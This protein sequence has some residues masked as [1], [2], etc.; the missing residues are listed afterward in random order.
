MA[1]CLMAP[2]KRL[3]NL[4]THS[5]T[6]WWHQAI[7]WTIVDLISEVHCHSIH[8]RVIFTQILK[9][10]IPKLC[11]KFTHL[12]ALPYLP[13][14][15]KLI[16]YYNNCLISAMR[17]LMLMKCH[18]I[19]NQDT[20]ASFT[21]KKYWLYLVY[22]YKNFHWEYKTIKRLFFLFSGILVSIRSY[23]HFLSGPLCPFH[24]RFFLLVIQIW[25]NYCSALPAFQ[26]T[27]IRRCWHGSQ[28]KGYSGES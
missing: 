7:T 22:M 1:F 25:C 5:L 24:V 14:D 4:I 2:A 12:K 10:S 21:I 18:L 17:F 28:I 6:H 16:F 19:L 13:W 15:N 23:L 27:G 9:I 3:L 11:L 26:T 8:S 20:G